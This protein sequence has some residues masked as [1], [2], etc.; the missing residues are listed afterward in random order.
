MEIE[1]ERIERKVIRAVIRAVIVR[2]ASD[3]ISCA[4]RFASDQLKNARSTKERL[5]F[6]RI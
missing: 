5:V 4:K 3:I 6:S 2:R 1:R